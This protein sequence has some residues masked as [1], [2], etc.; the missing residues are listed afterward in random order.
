MSS[1][2]GV[3]ITRR[4]ED[5]ARSQAWLAS[6]LSVS[7]TMVS[8]IIRGQRDLSGELLGA[9]S[10]ILRIPKADLKF[11]SDV[12]K[13]DLRLDVSTTER[14]SCAL[15]LARVW[16]SC[17]T[18]ELGELQRLAES[19]RLEKLSKLAPLE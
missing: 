10:S 8:L 1:P 5:M 2:V 14:R 7:G 9:V 15:A 19:F 13:G 17:T 4:L 18:R 3:L 16:S 12:Q 6:R 11:A